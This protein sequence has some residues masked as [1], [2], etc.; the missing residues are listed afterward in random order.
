MVVSNSGGARRQQHLVN[1]VGGV[2]LICE[3]G[4]YGEQGLNLFADPHGLLLF[5][6]QNSIDIPDDRSPKL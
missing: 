4:H 3:E 1:T 6:A 2:F 5:L